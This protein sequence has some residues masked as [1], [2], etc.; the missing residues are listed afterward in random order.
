[1]PACLPVRERKAIPRLTR[2]LEE[3]ALPEPVIKMALRRYE[4]AL[5]HGNL[6]EAVEVTHQAFAKRPG[7]CLD[8]ESH[9]QQL[10]V[11]PRIPTIL[12]HAGIETVGQL[13]S[14]SYRELLQ[15]P[16]I[17]EKFAG[18]IVNSLILAGFKNHRLTT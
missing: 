3:S 15:V 7:L 11:N 1:M 9:V 13:L 5:R 18:E 2:P 10:D 4:I 8:A 12:E 14:L 17:N 16:Q 6:S